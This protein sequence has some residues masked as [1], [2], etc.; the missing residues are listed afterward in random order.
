MLP[1][2]T[3][4]EPMLTPESK[5]RSVDTAA[6]ELT[7]HELEMIVAAGGGGLPASVTHTVRMRGKYAIV[8]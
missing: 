5:N 2:E 3:N 8:K 1:E 6:G 4:H 7:A